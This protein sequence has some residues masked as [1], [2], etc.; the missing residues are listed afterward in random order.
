MQ[1]HFG[2]HRGSYKAE[3]ACENLHSSLG[4]SAGNIG[5]APHCP[6]PPFTLTLLISTNSIRSIADQCAQFVCC[7]VEVNAET[8]KLAHDQ[9]SCIN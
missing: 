4:L 1:S 2:E 7:A 8:S 5:K 3:P 9:N 6:L